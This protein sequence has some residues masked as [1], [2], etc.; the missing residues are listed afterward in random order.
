MKNRRSAGR[1]R[2]IDYRFSPYLSVKFCPTMRAYQSE[3]FRKLSPQAKRAALKSAIAAQDP[4]SGFKREFEVDGKV[5]HTVSITELP[6]EQVEGTT[7]AK[8]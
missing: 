6:A 7:D 4:N 2:L 8:A 3:E 5:Y 1:V